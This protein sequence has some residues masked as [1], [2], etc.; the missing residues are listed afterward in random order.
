MS[1]ASPLRGPAVRWVI[2]A[3]IL[4]VA[5]AVALWPR[6]ESGSIE[7]RKTSQQE[8]GVSAAER[9]AAGLT[10]CPSAASGSSGSGPLA[11]LA[12]GCLADGSRTDLAAA[13]AGKPALVNLW[14]YWCAPCATELPHLQEFAQRAGSALTVVTVHSDPDEAKALARLSGLGITLPG[15]SDPSAAVRSAVGAPPVLPVSVLLRADGSVASVEVRTFADVTDIADT[16][17][18]KL[19]ITV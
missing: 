17:A 13:L 6:D 5:A 14:A 7:T 4:V 1:G 2:A 12:V 10:A 8:S 15:F 18:A 11:G 16:V 19:G 9:A 3:L